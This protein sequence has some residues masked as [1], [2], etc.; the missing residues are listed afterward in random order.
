MKDVAKLMLCE[1]VNRKQPFAIEYNLETDIGQ[2]SLVI[3]RLR[4]SSIYVSGLLIRS[5]VPELTER[6]RCPSDLVQAI[7]QVLRELGVG[8]VV[9]FR[10]ISAR[11]QTQAGQ[12]LAEP[13]PRYAFSKPVAGQ[14]VPASGPGPKLTSK[15]KVQVKETSLSLFTIQ[16]ELQT[17]RRAQKV[18]V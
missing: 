8:D 7:H 12:W 13:I 14:K 11:S 18:P 16:D 1:T 5:E 10:Q 15:R 4:A 6:V 9:E 2:L 17:L 3:T